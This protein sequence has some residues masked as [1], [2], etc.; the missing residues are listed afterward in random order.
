MAHNNNK[1]LLDSIV[2]DKCFLFLKK[3]YSYGANKEQKFVTPKDGKWKSPHKTPFVEPQELK[4][5][6]VLDTAGLR[7]GV[8]I[9]DSRVNS[10]LAE[11]GSNNF[12]I[13]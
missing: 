6:A 3:I 9:F 2:C 1:Y 12:I 11:P 10:G 7:K 8:V 4:R 13:I 5:W